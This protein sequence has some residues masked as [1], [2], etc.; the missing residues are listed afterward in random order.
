[1]KSG[2][3]GKDSGTHAIKRHGEK[4]FLLCILRSEN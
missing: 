2:K 3:V 1:M 4:E